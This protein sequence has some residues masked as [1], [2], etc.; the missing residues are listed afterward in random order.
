M[1]CKHDAQR[2][3]DNPHFRPSGYLSAHAS[4]RP[5][6][7]LPPEEECSFHY[8]MARERTPGGYLTLRERTDTTAEPHESLEE[9]RSVGRSYVTDRLSDRQRFVLMIT[10]ETRAWKNSPAT[11]LQGTVWNRLPS[12]KPVRVRVSSSNSRRVRSEGLPLGF[13]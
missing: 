2:A 4:R 9:T 13:F 7:H 10:Q 8:V 6:V 1:L 11:V 5:S 12:G 3:N